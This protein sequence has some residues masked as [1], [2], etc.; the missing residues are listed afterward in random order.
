M[1]FAAG[2]GIQEPWYIER[3]VFEKGKGNQMFSEGK[4]DIYIDFQKGSKF[5]SKEKGE[6]CPVHDTV[7]RVW[8]HANFFQ[9]ECYL[10]ARVPRIRTI[11]GNIQ[12]VKVPWAGEGSSFTL[13]FESLSMLYVR[14]GMSLSGAG[15]MQD[16]DGRVIGRIIK[17]YVE[18]AKFEQPIKVSNAIGIDEVSYKK[19][20]DY[21]T[22]V[23]DAK[24]Q[25]VLGVA[26]GKD[27]KAVQSAFGEMDKRDCDFEKIKYVSA[28]LSP[29]YTSAILNDLPQVSIVYDRFHVESLLNKAIDTLCKQ[30]TSE[31]H[32]LKKTKYLWLRNNSKLSEHQ[33]ERIHYLSI[34][35][36]KLG[37]AYRLKEMF[38]LI[39][40]E[41]H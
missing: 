25:V 12:Q 32:L 36:P 33:K 7:E 9:H 37:E 1:I 26:E 21:L 2:L 11:D 6:L 10:H 31:F 23:S 41:A 13:L 40:N 24:K 17:S 14:E 5:S 18:K 16:V 38:K 29:A 30:E 27:Q 8:R 19:G 15:R 4:L 34:C 39:Y 28:D 20:H 22:I 3:V 35:F